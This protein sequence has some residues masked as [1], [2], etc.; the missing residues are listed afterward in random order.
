MFVPQEGTPESIQVREP[1]TS[2]PVS[3]VPASSG[4]VRRLVLVNSQQPERSATA[5]SEGASNGVVRQNRFEALRDLEEV[6]ELRSET[7]SADVDENDTDSE[8]GSSEVDEGGRG[9]RHSTHRRASGTRRQSPECCH[10]H[11]KFG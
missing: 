1:P 8:R 6:R 11:G 9:G 7:G 4:A 2:A 5:T 10:W 3:T